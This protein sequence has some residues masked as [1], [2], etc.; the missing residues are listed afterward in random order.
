MNEE[1]HD[2][3]L[4]LLEEEYKLI[5]KRIDKIN[6]QTKNLIEI[7]GQKAVAKMLKRS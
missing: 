1:N 4:K 5:L 2:Y 3:Q 7:Y 6:E